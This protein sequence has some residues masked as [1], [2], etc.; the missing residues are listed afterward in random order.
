MWFLSHSS[1][2]SSAQQPPV[3]SGCGIGQHGH[4]VVHFHHQKG[5]LNSEAVRAVYGAGE[6]IAY[7]VETTSV[8]Q[9]LHSQRKGNE[10]E[11]RSARSRVHRRLWWT[12][13]ISCKD[14]V[15]GFSIS[16]ATL[17]PQML[18]SCEFFLGS[19]ALVSVCMCE[20]LEALR[21]ERDFILYKSYL[22]YFF[23]PGGQSH[24]AAI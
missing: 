15:P 20:L 19:A 2:V 8:V 7:W 6:R 14:G 9:T 3:G 24:M 16:W 17:V 1:H 10:E 18:S 21:S 4:P 22:I 5:Q 13:E 12:F 11:G 23:V